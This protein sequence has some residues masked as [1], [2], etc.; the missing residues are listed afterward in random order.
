[1]NPSPSGLHMTLSYYLP[2]SVLC[3]GVGGGGCG[4][5]YRSLPLGEQG[6]CPALLRGGA[7]RGDGRGGSRSQIY[8][9]HYPLLEPLT[10]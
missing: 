5:G 4:R 3:P 10:T 2:S 7:Q 1:M 6:H 9:E 8:T